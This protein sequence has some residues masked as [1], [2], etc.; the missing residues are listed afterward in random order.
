MGLMDVNGEGVVGMQRRF[1]VL[2]VGLLLA[3]SG[4]SKATT[5]TGGT[6]TPP[7]SPAASPSAS[8]PAGATQLTLAHMPTGTATLSWDATSKKITAKL[9]MSGFTPGSSHAMHIHNGSCLNQQNPPVIPFPDITADASGAA[10]VTVTSNAVA[11]GIPTN[12]YLNIHLAP[13]VSL[14]SPTDVSFTPIACADIPTGTAAAGPVTLTM[15]ALPQAGQHPTATA[16]LAYDATAKSLTVAVTA[17]GLVTGSVHAAHLH[18]GSCAA[19]G[20]VVYA[21]TDITADATGNAAVTTVVPNVSTAPPASGWYLNI[22]IGSSGQILANGKPT[23]LFEPILCA[24]I[25]G[26][27]AAAAS[28]SASAAASPAAGAPSVDIRQTAYNPSTVNASAGQ[29]VTWK[30]DDSGTQHTV[31]ADDGSFDSGPQSSGTFTHTFATAG[32][33]AFHCKIHASMTG[34]VVVS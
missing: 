17:S 6:P 27:P 9:D 29:T 24:D 7:A 2:A 8:A 18:A 13:G 3:A 5:T 28:P 4:C 11:A 15:A 34:V 21:L 32:R 20:A 25:H 12:A 14:G 19:Q 1:V 26:A 23:L 30:F 33:F 31:T 10:N 16:S 22:H